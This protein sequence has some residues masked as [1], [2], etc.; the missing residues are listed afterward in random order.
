MDARGVTPLHLAL[1]RLRLLGE[2]KSK[3]GG[4]D[5]V[6]GGESVGEG[7]VEKGGSKVPSFRKKEMMHVSSIH[8]ADYT[9]HNANYLCATHPPSLPPSPS[10]SPFPSP[11]LSPFSASSSLSYR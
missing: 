8:E 10:L 7:G 11:S 5:R 2:G 3:E 6:M 9:I 4:R 1:S